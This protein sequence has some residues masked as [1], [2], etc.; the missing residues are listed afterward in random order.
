M[1][2]SE[3][4]RA[5]PEE[6]IADLEALYDK[7]REDK[8]TAS[9]A[10]FVSYLYA[11]NH[12]DTEILRKLEAYDEVE[13]SDIHNLETRRDSAAD[14]SP[15]DFSYGERPDRGYSVLESIGEGGMGRIL[16]ARDNYLQR[17][18]AYNKST[19]R[20]QLTARC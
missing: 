13:L 8:Q 18:V 10:R 6:K 2:F 9:V 15:L 7:F 11:N 19:P 4:K 17:K 12:I 16:L 5:I 3:L 14:G 20:K 1:L